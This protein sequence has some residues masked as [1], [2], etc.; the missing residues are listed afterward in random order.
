MNYFNTPP[1]PKLGRPQGNVPRFIKKHYTA[2]RFDLAYVIS[3]F[4]WAEKEYN[5]VKNWSITKQNNRRMYEKILSL[6]SLHVLASSK[7]FD[8]FIKN[9][10]QELWNTI[11]SAIKTSIRDT[12]KIYTSL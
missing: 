10:N 3:L 6:S 4:G 5:D 9:M 8:K 11:P 7:E 12:Y 1:Q 2:E